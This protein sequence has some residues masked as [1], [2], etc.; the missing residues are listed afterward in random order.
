M[1]LFLMVLFISVNLCAMEN[2]NDS[3]R[4]KPYVKKEYKRLSKSAV[5]R[6]INQQTVEN[7][8]SV[9]DQ[10]A[11]LH[12]ALRSTPHA[13]SYDQNGEAYVDES[14]LGVSDSGPSQ[15]ETIQKNT[16]FH[17]MKVFAFVLFLVLFLSLFIYRK[18]KPS[19]GKNETRIR[20]SIS[21]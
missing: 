11:K 19:S 2:I 1:K 7:N 16:S 4:I 17:R 15:D 12:E 14:K 8:K 21:E 10:A 9:M 13:V 5:A 6:T 3:Q 18:F 20:G